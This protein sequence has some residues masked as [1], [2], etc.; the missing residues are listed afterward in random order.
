MSKY[1]YLHKVMNQFLK[2]GVVT[3]YE[4]MIIE[5]A[6]GIEIKYFN[7]VGTKSEKIRIVGKGDKFEMTVQEDDKKDKK[8]LTKDELVA[9]LKKNKKLK[10]AVDFSKTQK[11]GAWLNK[12][13]KSKTKTKSKSKSKSMSMSMSRSVPMSKSK[14]KSKSKS[15]SKTSSKPKSAKPKSAKPKSAKSKA[16]K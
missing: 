16:K 15:K 11:G 6:K 12:S 2:D 1:A 7:K 13:A 9:E 10:F 3:T 14:T 4:E 8:M 5:N